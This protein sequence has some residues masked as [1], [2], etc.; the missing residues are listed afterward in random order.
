M[1]PRVDGAIVRGR[2][3]GRS[4]REARKVCTSV[5]DLIHSVL[6]GQNTAMAWPRWMP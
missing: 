3:E 6:G 5:V 1:V 4:I 2:E